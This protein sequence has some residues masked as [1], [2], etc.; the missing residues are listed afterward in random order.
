[1]ATPTRSV[2]IEACIDSLADAKTAAANGAD[3]LEL[4]AALDL[5]GL[6][7]S[8]DLIESVKEQVNIPIKVMI[9]QRSGDFTYTKDD[10]RLIAKDIELVRSAGIR[11][12]VYGSLAGGRLDMDDL[13]KVYALAQP[14][15]MTIHKAIDQSTD[16]L[17]DVLELVKWAHQD[18]V[19]LSILSSGQADT[20]LEGTFRLKRM[21]QLCG[22]KVELIVAGKVTPR[23]LKQ[24][25]NLIPAPA[26]H[27]RHIL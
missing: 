4:C 11:D 21:Q 16:P 8:R 5:D 12:I 13:K 19:N 15:T 2:I 6:T 10:K 25:I 17:K 20:A 27:G 26:F 9:R 3:R 18:K 1:M 14:D 7:P 24:L 23:N 22:D